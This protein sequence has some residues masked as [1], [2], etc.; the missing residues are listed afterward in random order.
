MVSKWFHPTSDE[1]W[2]NKQYLWPFWSLK[3]LISNFTQNPFQR[4]KST[5]TWKTKTKLRTPKPHSLESVRNNHPLRL[6]IRRRDALVS[7]QP[8]QSL[9]STLRLVRDHPAKPKAIAI[10]TASEQRNREGSVHCVIIELP[11][12]SAPKD[13]GGRTEVDG[14]VRR[15]SVHTL[16]PEPHVL[17]LL[18]DEASRYGDLVAAYD[19][20]SL[21]VQEVLGYDRRQTTEHVVSSVDHHS[22]RADTWAGHHFRSLSLSLSL[23]LRRQSIYDRSFRARVSGSGVCEPGP[24]IRVWARYRACL[25]VFKWAPI[26]LCIFELKILKAQFPIWTFFYVSPTKV[27]Y[28]FSQYNW[29][30]GCWIGW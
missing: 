8:R 6:V 17:H 13:F 27:K 28:F 18:P 25:I 26:G 14:A 10:K 11:S 12:D 22:L 21:A 30:W 16:S 3:T 23:P 15:L 2:P 5:N 19:G 1:S 20:Y 9:S 29:N 24:C 4:D 7:L